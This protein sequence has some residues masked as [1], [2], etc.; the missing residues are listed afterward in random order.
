MNNLGTVLKKT[1]DRMETIF[2]SKGLPVRKGSRPSTINGP[3]HVQSDGHGDR[4]YLQQLVDDVLTWPYVESL[5]AWLGDA[6]ALPIRLEGAATTND[7]SA[8]LSGREF[9]RVL[10]EGPT[11]YLALPLVC[12]HWAIV[13]GWAE[14]H[15]LQSCG[16]MPAGAVV[17][18]TPKNREELAV[19]YPFSLRL[20]TLPAGSAKRTV[21]S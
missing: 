17:V 10:R 5:P 14:P 8:F 3:L 21:R 2:S 1:E 7:P 15:Y 4:K 16:L 18:Y 19:C 6:N 11:I 20:I 9:G 13:R 12:A